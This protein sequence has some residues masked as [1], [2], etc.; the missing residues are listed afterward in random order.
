MD[1]IVPFGTLGTNA[2][3][4]QV[5]TL[6]DI[7][8]EMIDTINRVNEYALNRGSLGGFD[9]GFQLLNEAIEGLNT[10]LHLIAGQSN[11]GKSALCIQLAWQ[12][13]QRNRDVTEDRPYKAYV[14]YFSLDDNA[15]TLLP[16]IVSIDQAIPINVVRFPQKYE[17]ETKL[18]VRRTAG[19]KSLQSSVGYF[20]MMDSTKGDT[21]EYIEDEIRRH[22]FALKEIDEAYKLVVFIDNF[23][24]IG[25][26]D[27]HFSSDTAKFD[28]LPQ[29]LSRICTT[30]DIPIVC[31]AEFRK[32]NGNRRPSIDDIKEATKIG[33]EAQVILLCYNE[34]GIRGESASLWWND[35][36]RAGEKMP[37]LE[38]KVGKNKQGSF[39]GRLYFEFWPERSYL[40]E[41]DRET[42]KRYDQMLLT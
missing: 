7:E 27:V 29:E 13:A 1:N 3:V 32:L 31:T 24:D 38:A 33:Y 28:Y 22:T 14:L 34:V 11:V 15:N 20:K 25:V 10:G 5:E 36:T 9:T 39:K 21:L 12:I 6:P 26:R 23:H 4:I 17:H 8:Q 40:H 42:A 16:R 35:P 18:M 19:F 41:A 37:I 30:Y 2:P